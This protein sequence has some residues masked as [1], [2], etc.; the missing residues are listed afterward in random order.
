MTSAER[1]EAFFAQDGPWKAGL[2]ALRR[3]MRARGLTEELK[4]GHPYYY[5]RGHKVVMIVA[6]KG[7]YGLWF[8]KGSLL[9]DKARLLVQA[10]AK[11]QGL[12]QMRF[13][14]MAGLRKASEDIK[15][16]VQEAV[17]LEEQGAKVVMKHVTAQDMP[18]EWRAKTKAVH[19]L[20]K[21]F[22]ALTP[23]RQRTY[24]AHFGGA[25]QAST[26]IARIDK[27]TKHILA[28]K[29]LDDK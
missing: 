13:T 24:L 9:K 4:W 18:V 7:Y 23:G 16:Y 15:A 27:F 2:N 25:K 22:N 3:I 29:G 19:G 17:L 5:H 6:T 11:T 10:D 14:D 21:A 28:G 20:Q 8:D 12:R 26:R 1:I